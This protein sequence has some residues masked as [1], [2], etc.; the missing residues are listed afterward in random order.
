MNTLAQVVMPL[1]CVWDDPESDIGYDNDYPEEGLSW[2][3]TAP[4]GRCQ[5]L[6]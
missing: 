4:S 1:T 5:I 6:P 3:S 2:F